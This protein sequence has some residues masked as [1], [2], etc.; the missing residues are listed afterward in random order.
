T[1]QAGAASGKDC[2]CEQKRSATPLI[3]GETTFPTAQAGAA[4]GKDCFCEQKRS[5]TP[6]IIQTIP[7][8]G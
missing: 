2:F 6:L 7:P 4:S 5:A 3:H 1:A 8:L